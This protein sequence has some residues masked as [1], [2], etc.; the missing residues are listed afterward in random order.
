MEAVF[1][2]SASRTLLS[3]CLLLILL[4]LLQ[5]LYIQK[6]LLLNSFEMARPPC[7]HGTNHAVLAKL[8]DSN[9]DDMVSYRYDTDYKHSN[10]H[11][12]LTVEQFNNSANLSEQT[13]Q[14]DHHPPKCLIIGVRKGGTR[15]LLQTIALHPD[16]KVAKKS[17][18]MPEST[19]QQVVIEKTPAYF[20]SP[21]APERVHSLN[22]KM[23]LILIVRDPVIRLISDFTQM[24]LL[25]LKLGEI[26]KLPVSAVVKRS[27]RYKLVVYGQFAA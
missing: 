18:Q 26:N 1:R 19:P 25:V 10:L 7:A 17:Q 12:Q 13:E 3:L 4:V 14:Q 8:R 9:T 23:K 22:A 16:V 6:S 24:K 5:I 20:I 2:S 21:E 11:K 27:N 15:A